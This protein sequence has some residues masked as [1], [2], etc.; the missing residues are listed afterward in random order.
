[1]EIRVKESLDI[2][3]NIIMRD[4]HGMIISDYVINIT[5]VDC[6]KCDY[7]VWRDVIASL[8]NDGIKVIFDKDK[9]LSFISQL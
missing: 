9:T 2:Y 4:V 8:L 1:M 7:E 3:E 6:D 5:N